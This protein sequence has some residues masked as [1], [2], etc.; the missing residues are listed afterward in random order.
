M[1]KNFIF[2]I[3]DNIRFLQELNEDEWGGLFSHPYS[4]LL[5]RLHEKYNLKIQ[6]NLFY[7]YKNFNLSQMTD[8]YKKEWEEAS[9]W[10]KLSFHSIKDN[11]SPY[12]NSDYNEVYN[13]CQT[14]QKEIIRFA[15]IDSLAKTTTIHYC[16]L[17]KK[18]L[19]AIKDCGIK[20]LLGLYGDEFAAKNSYNCAEEERKQ[21][22]KGKVIEKEG[23][24][25]AG[26]DI[27]LNCWDINQIIER[28]EKIKDRQV[29][30]VMIHEQYFYGDYVAY[31][32]NFECKLSETFNFLIKNDFKSI[33]YEEIIY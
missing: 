7:E 33:I 8:K 22:A 16:Q 32:P 21:I 29:I 25:F 4:S 23:L 9:S 13:E 24:F 2:T 20:G 18:G 10:L 11:V 26:I 1:D 27:V 28:L 31:Q 6:L 19:F 5:K 3:D 30:K 17:S 15:G 14:V 12:L